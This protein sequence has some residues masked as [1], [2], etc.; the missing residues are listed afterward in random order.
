MVELYNC[1]CIDFMKLCF[2]TG[3]KFDYII[4]SPPYNMN[5]KACKGGK[6]VSRVNSNQETN[7][8]R[9]YENYTD[10]MQPEDYYE[11]IDKFID[12]ALH[13]SRLTF[14]NIQMVSWNKKSLFKLLGKYCDKIKEVIIWDKI[15][16]QP[17]MQNGVM[18]SQYEFIIVFDN[19]L[20]QFRNFIGCGFDRGTETN[21]W[22]I[23]TTKNKYNKAAFP[24]ELI[25]RVLRD[26]TKEGE[27]I[28]DPFMGSGTCGIV[29]LNMKRNFIG[30][31]LDENMFNI[32]K[33]RIKQTEIKQKSR[34]F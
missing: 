30:C 24:E 29:S 20:A 13:I 21:L 25:I 32:A 12:Y 9:K 17:A 15:N 31:E 23:K 8:S 34:L 18:N 14:F 22:R 5:V 2:D 7:F 27:T 4:T 16:A 26:F 28:F 33:E 1:N 19:E 3:I 11:F 6:F 10:D